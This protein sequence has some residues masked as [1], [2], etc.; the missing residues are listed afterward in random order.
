MCAYQT[1]CQE[2]STS[3]GF[4]AGTVLVVCPVTVLPG[5][6]TTASAVVSARAIFA[7][8]YTKV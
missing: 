2:S 1:T 5:G 4:L 8:D 7:T 3:A 6:T